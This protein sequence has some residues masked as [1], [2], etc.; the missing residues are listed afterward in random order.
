MTENQAIT[1]RRSTAVAYLRRSTAQQE[2]SI[3]DQRAAI[4]RYATEHNLQ[5]IHFYT[6]DAIT[7]TRTKGR[8]AFQAMMAAAQQRDCKLG[9]VI[10]YDI[11]RFGRVDNSWMLDRQEP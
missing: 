8:K 2:Q 4:E 9:I 11:E 1:K 6:D 3:P 10:V 5:L 7:G